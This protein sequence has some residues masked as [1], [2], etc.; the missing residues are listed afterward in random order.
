MSI[1]GVFSVEHKDQEVDGV[2]QGRVEEQA[3]SREGHAAVE[4]V[5]VLW[6]V[7][8]RQKSLHVHQWDGRE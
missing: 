7:M 8:Q 6:E 5:F 2:D 3:G 1:A 4:Q